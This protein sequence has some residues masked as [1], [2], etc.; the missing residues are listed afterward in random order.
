[1]QPQS[2]PYGTGSIQF[3]PGTGQKQ[4][5]EGPAKT[6]DLDMGGIKIPHQLVFDPATGQYSLKNLMAGPSGG[7]AGQPAAGG[8][9]FD[10]STPE[11]VAAASAAMA[12]EKKGAET[13]AEAQAKYYNA[14]HTGLAGSA[15][16][17]SQ[18]K[19]NIDVARQIANSP[20]FIA[21]TFNESGLAMQRLAAS[22]GMN[23]KAAAG[24]ELFDQISAKILSDQ[25][26]GLKSMSSEAGEVG[27]RIFKPF[28]DLEEKASIKPGDTV[29]GIMAKLDY[30]DKQGNLFMKYADI[31]DDYIAKNGRL[32]AGFDKYLRHEIASS[33]IPNVVP[34]EQSTAP[35]PARCSTI[36][37]NARGI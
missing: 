26:S 27:G 11:G 6:M 12:A 3:I 33:R 17:A 1:M 24:R 29:P 13:G 4:Y 5:V 10:F 9:K 28:L 7:T 36:N 34:Q 37:L 20:D 2:M 18:Q 15:M 31:A 23:P 19:Q 14:V 30:L 35:T 32:D 8:S 16:V 25:M 21:G 22:L